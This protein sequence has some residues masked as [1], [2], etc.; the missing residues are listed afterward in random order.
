MSDRRSQAVSKGQDCGIGGVRAGSGVGGKDPVETATRF[1]FRGV[2]EVPELVFPSFPHNRVS[3]VIPVWNRWEYT[4]RCLQAVLSNTAG[5]PYEVI[6]VDNG[7][8]DSTEEL[9]EKTENI[10]IIQN[11]SN[12][13]YLLACNQGAEAGKGDYLV[14]LN[15]DTE[16]LTGWLTELVNTVDAD[17]KAGAVGAKLVYPDGRLQE[18]GGIIF[19]DGRGWNFGNGDNPAED[20]YNVKCEV[21]YCSGACLLTRKDLFEARGGF[22]SRYVP[23]YYEETDLCFDLRKMGYSVWYNPKAVVIHYE[24]VTAGQNST[25]GF[26][27]YIDINRLKFVEKWKDQLALQ[28]AHPTETGRPPLTACRERLGRESV[29]PEDI[30]DRMHKKRE[31]GGQD[32][33]P[34]VSD[35]SLLYRTLDEKT[36]KSIDVIEK[37]AAYYGHGG[38]AIEWAGG[39][40][41]VAVLHLVR[42]AFGGI[43]P[44]CVINTVSSAESSA[45]GGLLE[46]LREAWGFEIKNVM[47]E[48][49][50]G[51]AALEELTAGEQLCDLVRGRVVESMGFRALITAGRCVERRSSTECLYFSVQKKPRFTLVRPLLHFGEV[52]LWQYIKENGVP[53]SEDD[54]AWG[55][56]LSILGNGSGEPTG[57]LS[58]FNAFL[59]VD[60]APPVIP[61]CTRFSLP[62]KIINESSVLWPGQADVPGACKVSLSYHWLDKNGKIVLFDGIRTPL[63]ESVHPGEAIVLNASVMTLLLPGDYLL[64]F[65]MVQEGVSWFKDKGSKTTRVA[66]T[67]RKG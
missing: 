26:R 16:P 55:R 24:S 21:D 41:S 1:A 65:D 60:E 44:F 3:I 45:R 32:P 64:E 37:A 25:G 14:F 31:G 48:E 29:P 34:L 7:S 4:C 17:R 36:S 27:R 38:V 53:F 59:S 50:A 12:K 6:I 52:D 62:V 46:R 18:A 35:I 51:K 19:S 30:L 13:G 5:V 67:I 33:V 20:I 40:D 9:L 22:D 63:E 57:F 42:R 23:A 54:F 8:T 43:I 49:E 15:N 2:E 10:G 39:E 61:V 58:E 56:A 28:D 66:V 47:P 11:T